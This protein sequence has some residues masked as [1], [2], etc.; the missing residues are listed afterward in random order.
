MSEEEEEARISLLVVQ[1]SDLKRYG[2]GKADGE[3]KQAAVG[4]LGLFHL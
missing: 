4:L 1:I 2:D 3:K